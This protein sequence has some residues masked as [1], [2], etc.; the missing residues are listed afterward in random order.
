[1]TPT[2]S[3][4]ACYRWAFQVSGDKKSTTLA[5]YAA[6]QVLK[7][8]EE[9]RDPQVQFQAIRELLREWI[10]SHKDGLQTPIKRV[11]KMLGVDAKEELAEAST[12][13]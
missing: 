1:M 4:T 11:A 8:C 2:D 3:I 6:K 9:S 13:S 10:A 12:Q 7:A 5:L